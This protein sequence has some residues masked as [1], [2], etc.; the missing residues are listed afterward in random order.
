VESLHTF[1]LPFVLYIYN[2]SFVIEDE[3]FFSPAR[4]VPVGERVIKDE[5]K[6]M[7]KD[8]RKMKG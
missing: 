8:K 6:W 5:K 2:S 4:M 1:L 7:R 3:H